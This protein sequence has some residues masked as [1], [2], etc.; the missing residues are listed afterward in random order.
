[1][2]IIVS[3]ALPILLTVGMFIYQ[4][5]KKRRNQKQIS[6]MQREISTRIKKTGTSK[7]SWTTHSFRQK[8]SK[9]IIS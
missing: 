8:Q 1:M 3:S 6:E 2:E 7:S 5:V 4:K 9:F